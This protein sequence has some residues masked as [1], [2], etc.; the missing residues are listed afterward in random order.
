M[1]S[2]RGC[3]WPLACNFTFAIPAY[4]HRHYWYAAKDLSRLNGNKTYGKSP[5]PT[6]PNIL[7]DHKLFDGQVKATF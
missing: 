7:L 4:P 6:N 1:R 3:I 5:L 2:K